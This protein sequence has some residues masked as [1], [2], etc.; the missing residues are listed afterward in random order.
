MSP[1]V[2]EVW[3]EGVAD[4]RWMSGGTRQRPPELACCPGLARRLLALMTPAKAPATIP[5]SSMHSH[6]LTFTD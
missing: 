4:P 6:D 2:L 3:D 5:Q 1:S